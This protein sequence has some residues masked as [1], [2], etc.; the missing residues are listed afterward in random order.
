MFAAKSATARA[1]GAGD[2]LRKL[3]AIPAAKAPR[4]N[5]TPAK[6]TSDA[7]WR[8]I[9]API[10]AE[11]GEDTAPPD[12]LKDDAKSMPAHIAAKANIAAIPPKLCCTRLAAITGP[13]K[14]AAGPTRIR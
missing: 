5:V 9:G 2:L 14:T 10:S 11:E 6:P 4:R 8:K 13:A 3:A 12:A 7:L 1:A